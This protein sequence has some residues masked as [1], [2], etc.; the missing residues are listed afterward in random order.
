VA[1]PTRRAK[2]VSRKNGLTG[3]GFFIQ[4]SIKKDVRLKFSTNSSGIP[5]TT[6]VS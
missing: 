4:G 3:D 5:A 2:P 1:H 6:G